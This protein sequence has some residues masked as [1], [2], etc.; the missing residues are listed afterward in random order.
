MNISK[1]FLTITAAAALSTIALT[2]CMPSMNTKNDNPSPT[3]KSSSSAS[4]TQ[5]SSTPTDL[6]TEDTG[7]STNV[8]EE[9]EVADSAAA[10]INTA[11]EEKLVGEYNAIVAAN[12]GTIT[13]E[14]LQNKPELLQKLT[15]LLNMPISHVNTGKYSQGGATAFVAGFLNGVGKSRPAGSYFLTV[16]PTSVAIVDATHAKVDIF[17]KAV[18]R[19]DGVDK[20]STQSGTILPMIKDAN[21]GWQIDLATILEANAGS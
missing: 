19:I 18:V 10:F 13:S 16:D 9:K 2:G 15:D 11:M 21:N 17:N 20:K 7:T 14:D 8:S 5:E 3:T 1:K 4:P 6:A 12:G